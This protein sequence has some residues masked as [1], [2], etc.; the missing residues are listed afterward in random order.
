[1]SAPNPVAGASL[2]IAAIHSLAIFEM[3]GG[4]DQGQPHGDAP[5]DPVVAV[6]WTGLTPKVT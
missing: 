5:I 4:P 1:V 3:R 6:L 2:F